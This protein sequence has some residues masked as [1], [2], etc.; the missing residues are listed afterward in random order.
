MM[1][2]TIYDVAVEKMKKT[3]SEMVDI[4]ETFAIRGGDDN[5]IVEYTAKKQE[6]KGMKI[7]QDKYDVYVEWA[8]SSDGLNKRLHEG[9]VKLVEGIIE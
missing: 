9:L 5:L 2:Y 1:V 7:W 3:S 6:L 8:I 4:I